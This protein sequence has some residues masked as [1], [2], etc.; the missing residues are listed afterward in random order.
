MA[1]LSITPPFYQ[2]S[3][4]ALVVV[5]KLITFKNCV[6]GSEKKTINPNKAGQVPQA[7]LMQKPLIKINLDAITQRYFLQALSMILNFYKQKV[8]NL[9]SYTPDLILKGFFV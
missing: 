7:S 6:R 4:P 8:K 2:Y 3:H 5:H 1:T 9:H